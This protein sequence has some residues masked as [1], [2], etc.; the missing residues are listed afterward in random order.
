MRYTISN[1]D[2]RKIENI[3]WKDVTTAYINWYT[4]FKNVIEIPTKYIPIWGYPILNLPFKI[5]MFIAKNYYISDMFK[6]DGSRMTN[7][8]LER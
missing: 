1:I 8:D 3:F 7:G 5:L 4:A 2:S 6:E